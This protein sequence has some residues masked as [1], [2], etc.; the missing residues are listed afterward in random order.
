MFW[1][2]LIIR[3][4]VLQCHQPELSEE[5]PVGVWG[6]VGR[7]GGILFGFLSFLMSPFWIKLNFIS[8]FFQ[9]FLIGFS[10][11]VK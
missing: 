8:K 2:I 11:I 9:K 6:G 4:T 7:V 5:G 3:L 1:K 10:I